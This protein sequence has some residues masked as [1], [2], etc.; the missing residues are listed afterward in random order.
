MTRQPRI[1]VTLPKATR[2]AITRLSKLT[3]TPASKIVAD[4]LAESTAV[5][6][7]I[8]DAVER[9]QKLSS[10]KSAAVRATLVDAEREAR[11]NAATVLVLLDRIG[12]KEPPGVASARGGGPG[13]SLAKRRRRPPSC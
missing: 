12:A 9:V 7:R 5:F 6:E 8:C 13:G 11:E 3:G 2:A 10:E 4:S 1:A